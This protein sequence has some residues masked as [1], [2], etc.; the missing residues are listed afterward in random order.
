MQPIPFMFVFISAEMANKITI[1]TMQSPGSSYIACFAFTVFENPSFVFD[2]NCK[3]TLFT[4][5][6]RPSVNQRPK[7]Y[8]TTTVYNAPYSHNSWFSCVL[9]QS[10]NIF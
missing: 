6:E 2:R 1:L 8:T 4:K 3:F 7:T 9:R 5:L 10:K